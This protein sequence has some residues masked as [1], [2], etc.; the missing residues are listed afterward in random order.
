MTRGGLE[1][2]V[3]PA[4]V[5]KPLI[6]AAIERH[7][8]EGAMLEI[9]RGAEIHAEEGGSCKI[10]VELPLRLLPRP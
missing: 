2:V 6:K 10:A 4:G 7:R 9:R 8:G 5:A 3:A 1:G